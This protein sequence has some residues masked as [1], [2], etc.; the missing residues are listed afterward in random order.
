[1]SQLYRYLRAAYQRRRWVVSH[2]LMEFNGAVGFAVRM[3]SCGHL[4]N[5]DTERPYVTRVRVLHPLQAF[6]RPVM[7]TRPDLHVAQSACKRACVLLGL[8]VLIELFADAE[9]T[10]LRKA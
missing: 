2:V 4:V 8:L 6:R 7:F 9:V 3:F 10:Q 1:M 5:D